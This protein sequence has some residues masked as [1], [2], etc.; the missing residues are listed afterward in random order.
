MFLQFVTGLPLESGEGWEFLIQRGVTRGSYGS[1]A[2]CYAVY[3]LHSTS[4]LTPLSSR[5]ALQSKLFSMECRASR[6][7]GKKI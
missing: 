5:A 7:A 3:L 6:T 1:L 2:F 4:L